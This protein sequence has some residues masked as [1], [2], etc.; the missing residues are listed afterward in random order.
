MESVA[1]Q[2]SFPRESTRSS[3][4]FSAMIQGM[5][6]LFLDVFPGLRAPIL[7]YGPDDD[8]CWVM[9]R[10]A[11]HVWT[12]PH[13][14]EEIRFAHDH[15]TPEATRNRILKIRAMGFGGVIQ[16]ATMDGT[17]P[18]A[19]HNVLAVAPQEITPFSI[20]HYGPNTAERCAIGLTLT[21][22]I[23][24]FVLRPERV[25]LSATPTSSQITDAIQ[26]FISLNG[27]EKTH[28]HTDGAW[29]PPAPFAEVLHTH[30]ITWRTATV[31]GAVSIPTL[32]RILR[33]IVDVQ[34]RSQTTDSVAMTVQQGSANLDAIRRIV[35]GKPITGARIQAV[36]AALLPLCITNTEDEAACRTLDDLARTLVFLHLPQQGPKEGSRVAQY[37]R[38]VLGS[39]ESWV[40]HYHRASRQGTP[41]VC[42]VPTWQCELRCQ[43]CTIKKQSGREMSLATAERSV[44]LLLSS[45]APNVA[46]HFFGGEPFLAWPLLS[47]I[48]RYG[49]EHA[50]QN[51]Q[52]L[53]TQFTTNAYSLTEA[54]LDVLMAYPCHFQLSL[55]GA[56][57]TQNQIRRVWK[58]GDSYARSPAHR[59][60]WFTA[61]N[62]SHEV[63]C[64]VHPTN[65]AHLV[66]NIKHIWDMGY[67]RV[68]VNYAI[69]AVWNPTATQQWMHSLHALGD[70]LRRRWASGE[71]VMVSNVTETRKRVRFNSHI[72]VD[73][74]GRIYNSNAFLY[75]ESA[76]DRFHLGHLDEGQSYTRYLCSS[77]GDEAFKAAWRWKGSHGSN[78]QMG[79]ILNRFCDAMHPH[80]PHDVPQH[81]RL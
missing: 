73:W 47:H 34:I 12:L 69:G 21:D 56:S 13:T 68:Q 23:P 9:D 61:R 51:G 53:H 20:R 1:Y 3:H 32:A 37:A 49:A 36:H 10:D 55:D 76:R 39:P 67:S 43:Y 50:A 25:H 58:T 65:V 79:A 78:A 6:R 57:T 59:A 77:S 29:T 31:R 8:C 42:I 14:V 5:N 15:C 60:H 81:A 19:M 4:N 46:L 33:S 72:T 18:Y 22:D 30:P 66:D 28:L 64:V 41:R 71:T 54:H 26:H 27:T 7:A 48:M 38:R 45:M 35:H 44:G 80:M 62:I 16:L 52:S 17:V 11:T 63:I 40:P 2:L 24:L 74:D 70:E 75:L